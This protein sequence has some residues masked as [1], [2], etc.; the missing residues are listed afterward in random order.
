MG[1]WPA[2]SGKGNEKDAHLPA[3]E[4]VAGVQAGS[5]GGQQTDQPDEVRLDKRHDSGDPQQGGDGGP[6]TA[7]STAGTPLPDL[8][9]TPPFGC[10]DSLG[11]AASPGIGIGGVD[12]VGHVGSPHVDFPLM[13][14]VPTI[15]PCT[16]AQKRKLG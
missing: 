16:A 9:P 8:T 13:N 3:P 4:Q 14:R 10:V 2:G 5:S 12:R 11:G 6:V 1:G 15:T 7:V